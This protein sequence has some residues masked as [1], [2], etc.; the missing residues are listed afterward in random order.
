MSLS[1]CFSHKTELVTDQTCPDC[2][3]ER[4]ADYDADQAERRHEESL[5]AMRRPRE[6]DKRSFTA[7]FVP[8]VPVRPPTPVQVSKQQSE[9]ISPHP[10]LA[11]LGTFTLP[12]LACVGMCFCGY[13]LYKTIQVISEPP[14]GEKN[15]NKD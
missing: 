13:I 12:L 1:Y 11:V 8:S 4:M 5:E 7:T 3:A 14:E 6:N 10:I 9:G 15:P 2:D